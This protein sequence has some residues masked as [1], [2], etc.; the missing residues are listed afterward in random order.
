VDQPNKGLAGARNTGA[1]HA[2]GR[3]VI[4]LDS[5]DLFFPWTLEVFAEA[6]RGH[7]MPAMISGKFHPFGDEGELS[8]FDRVPTRMRVFKDYVSTRARSAGVAPSATAVRRDAYFAAGGG[9]EVRVMFEDVEIWFKVGTSPGFVFIDEPASAGY[10]VGHAQMMGNMQKQLDGFEWIAGKV[11][12]GAFPDGGSRRRDMEDA[13][14]KHAKSCAFRCIH[15]GDRKLAM[16]F[17]KR[18]FGWQVRNG[19]WKFLVGFPAAWAFGR[20]PTSKSMRNQA[21]QVVADE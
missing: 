1:E 7:G 16:T 15:A 9:E 21:K 14:A 5:D 12:R 8:R 4:F 18:T 19:E 20:A 2:R 17:Y 6:A 10:R 11:A 3:Y 13:L